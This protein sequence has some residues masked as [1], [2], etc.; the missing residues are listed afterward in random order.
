[1]FSGRCPPRR[2]SPRGLNRRAERPASGGA[3]VSVCVERA[4]GEGPFAASVE[5]DPRLVDLCPFFRGH[6]RGLGR[7][8][9]GITEGKGSGFG[10]KC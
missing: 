5:A 8:A 3:G 2:R 6:H 1:M 4:L 10:D 9:F 7:V